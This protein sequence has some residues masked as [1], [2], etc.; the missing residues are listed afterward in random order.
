M[1]HSSKKTMNAIA[2]G[3]S[4]GQCSHWGSSRDCDLLVNP[5]TPAP[6][7]IQDIEI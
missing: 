7:G 2:I 1:S 5:Q 4:L 6:A 3:S